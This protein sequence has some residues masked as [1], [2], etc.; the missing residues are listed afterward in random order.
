MRIVSELLTLLRI[1]GIG[2]EYSGEELRLSG[3][4]DLSNAQS[5]ASDYACLLE[6]MYAYGNEGKNDAGRK[7]LKDIILDMYDKLLDKSRR[8]D[9]SRIA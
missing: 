7:M 6:S 5:K 1:D 2:V 9:E 3:M 8:F 4:R